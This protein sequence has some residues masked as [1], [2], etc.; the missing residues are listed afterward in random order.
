MFFSKIWFTHVS[1]GYPF[2][3]ELGQ[4]VLRLDRL[5][6]QSQSRIDHVDAEEG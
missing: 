1:D 3:A 5:V 6:T 2:E 4:L